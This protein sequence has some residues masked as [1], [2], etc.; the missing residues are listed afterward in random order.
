LVGKPEGKKPLGLPSCL[1]PQALEPKSWIHFLCLP[2]RV[3]LIF[4]ALI[5]LI[6]IR[7]KVE[8]IKVFAT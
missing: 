6:N 2:C 4:L 5:I 1:F 7:R 3:Y 8:I